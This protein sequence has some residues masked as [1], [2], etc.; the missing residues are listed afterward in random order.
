MVKVDTRGHCRDLV[1]ESF[2]SSKSKSKQTNKKQFL[3]TEDAHIALPT[4]AAQRRLD[5]IRERTLLGDR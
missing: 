5:R 4:A 1:F 2:E 3:E